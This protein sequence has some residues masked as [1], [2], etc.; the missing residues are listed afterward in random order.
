VNSLF[1]K[2]KGR[3]NEMPF[4][5]H[6][7][8]LRWRMLYIVIAIA[9]GA[10]IGFWLVMQ[11]DV[12]GLLIDP[13]KPF[14]GSS[15]LKYLSP[16]DP[17]FVTFKLGILVGFLLASP[18]VIYQVWSFF[19][20]ALLPSERR[21]IIPA[22]YFGLALF[23]GGVAMAYTIVLPIT[24]QF[25]MGF[26][27]DSL[28]QAIVVNAYLAVVTRLLLAFG[29]VFE[30][31]V[32][33]VILS[34]MG[35]VTPEFLA[36][37]RRH[38]LVGITVLASVITPG[39]VITVTVMMMVPLYLLYELSIVLSRMVVRRRAAIGEPAEV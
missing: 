30:L 38:A 3:P 37:K 1:I 24:L 16:T 31:P 17:F 14:L 21:V 27:T 19:A 13:I 15:K 26:Q 32:V 20:P 35:L 8:E 12:L 7:E 36:S 5:D 11:Y 25:T 4:L 39:D 2:T 29:F 33:I 28:E 10:G 23:A 18:V 9:I 34:A 6:L 22:L